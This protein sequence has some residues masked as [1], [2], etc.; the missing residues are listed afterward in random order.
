MYF[1]QLF[2]YQFTICIVSYSYSATVETQVI[3]NF[4]GNANVITI[5]K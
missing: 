3:G 5:C 2:L 1:V 4:S